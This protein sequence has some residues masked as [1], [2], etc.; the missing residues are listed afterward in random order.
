MGMTRLVLVPGGGPTWPQARDL[1]AGRGYPVQ[2]QM[3][4]GQLAFPDE[5]PPPEWRELRLKTPGG[6]VT[7]RRAAGGVECVVWGNADEAL[8]RG[9]N[10]VAWAFAVASGGRVRTDG[11]DQTPADFLAAAE[12]PPLLQ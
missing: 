10:A 12:A 1:L 2:V 5:E 4:D 8:R 6:T 9:W 11:G 7:V 3:I